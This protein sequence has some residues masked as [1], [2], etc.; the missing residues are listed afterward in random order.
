MLW[1]RAGLW[2]SP[3]FLRLWS[4]RTASVV[5][6]EIT[7]VALPLTAVLLLE[8]SPLQ[9]GLLRAVGLAP[10][11]L[12]GLLAGVWVDR[13]AR[14]PLLIG[15]DLGRAALVA[16]VP[17]LGAAALLRMEVLY[18]VAFAL[19][20]LTV[21][22]VIALQS[23][24]PWLAR[25]PQLVEANAKLQVS[26]AVARVAGP[27][28][29]GV[30]VQAVGAP[31]AMLLDAASFVVS[32]ACTGAIT[33][34]EAPPPRREAGARVLGEAG[35]GLRLLFGSRLLWATT[36][37]AAT[38][39]LFFNMQQAVLLL[40]LVRDAALTPAVVGLALGVGSVGGLLGAVLAGRPPPFG[41]GPTLLVAFVA[42][43]FSGLLVSL[44][45]VGGGWA[46]PLLVAGQA[47]NG[48]SFPVYFVALMSLR[49]ALTPDRLQGRATASF[50]TVAW[51]VLPIG[52]LAGGVLGD[53]FGLRPV[54]L[55]SGVG[56][57]AAPLWLLLSPVAHL[58]GLPQTS[59]S[60]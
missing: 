16:L 41:F 31:L 45:G 57:A 22:Y 40:A 26:G 58:R 18:A 2:R 20:T 49:Q 19:G 32:A 51:G 5:G 55:A 29:G 14:R 23:F 8:A 13:L 38:L 10:Q 54:L 33:A 53:A 42:N 15:A 12:F 7:G 47:L 36:A 46:V 1:P 59:G 52:S 34:R 4:G 28:L 3:D 9:M 17:L 24:L 56:M 48:V 30:L 21:L 11:L 43:G 39:N 60:P 44:S 6:N 25:G 50:T 37:A 27:G 35:E